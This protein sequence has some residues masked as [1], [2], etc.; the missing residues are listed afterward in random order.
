[1][2]G[3]LHSTIH[4]TLFL[5]EGLIIFYL[6]AFLY[7]HAN[8]IIYVDAEFSNSGDRREGVP[9]LEREERSGSIR[10]GGV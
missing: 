7:L 4:I 8:K 6:C 5:T 1:V 10:E 2:H 9:I 3:E